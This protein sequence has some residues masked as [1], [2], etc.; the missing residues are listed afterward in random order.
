MGA[1]MEWSS[2]TLL[3]IDAIDLPHA[4]QIG[5]FLNERADLGQLVY[6]TGKT[7]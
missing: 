3:A 2:A 6:E 7:G 5:D 4:Q 1:A